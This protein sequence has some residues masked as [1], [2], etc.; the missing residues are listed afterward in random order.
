M[1]ALLG[2]GVSE[3][4]LRPAAREPTR[5]FRRRLANRLRGNPTTDPW[6]TE[7]YA[8]LA[9]RV[10]RAVPTATTLIDLGCGD[11]L[12]T[13]Q[14]MRYMP[15][16]K[17]VTG[18]DLEPSEFWQREGGIRFQIGDAANPPFG[19]GAADVVIAKDLL[20]HMADPAVGVKAIARCARKCA[21][22]IEANRDN[23]IMDLYTRHNGDQHLQASQ[24]RDLLRTEAPTVT[25]RF[26]SVVAYPFYLPPVGGVESVWVWPVTGAMLVAFK[27][28]RSRAMAR[29][30]SSAINSLP[31]AA[32]FT[33]AIGNV[34]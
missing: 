20:H 32:P 4:N 19:R 26:E 5:G 10:A 16:L 12:F 34:R 11:A 15:A 18:L 30:M 9:Q 8:I 14:L 33:L 6:K 17:A 13:T 24:F 25:W 2:L 3:S 31:W 21:V 27:L 23:P 1:T 28:F 7:Q 22:I 29:R